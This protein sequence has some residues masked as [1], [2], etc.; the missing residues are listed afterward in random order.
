MI[1]VGLGLV[2]VDRRA[3]GEDPKGLASADLMLSLGIIDQ[4]VL[5][6]RP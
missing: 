4:F 2:V 3:E 6:G 5:L 1:V